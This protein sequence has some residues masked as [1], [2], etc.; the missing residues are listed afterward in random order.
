MNAHIIA[1]QI[2][3]IEQ[4]GKV[5]QSM[6]DTESQIASIDARA[7]ILKLLIHT[8]E[9]KE[10]NEKAEGEETSGPLDKEAF[11]QAVRE[12]DGK[13]KTKEEIQKAVDLVGPFFPAYHQHEVSALQR[14]LAAH[15]R[16][17]DELDRQYERLKGEYREIDREANMP[18]QAPV[19]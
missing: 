7:T 9:W 5:L 13:E 18:R 14:S 19:A 2:T 6:H 8:L 16:R 12:V 11:E 3:A 17:R 1:D 15:E 10:K 4:R